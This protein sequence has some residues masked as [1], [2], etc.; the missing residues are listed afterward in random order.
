[1]IHRFIKKSFF[2]TMTFSSYNVL[3]VNY[4]EYVSMNDQECKIRSE[5]ININTNEPM[6]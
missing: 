5:I 3:N 4:V 6:L 1:M 2:T